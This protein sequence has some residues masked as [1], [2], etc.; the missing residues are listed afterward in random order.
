MVRKNEDLKENQIYIT[1]I[2]DIL[3][4]SLNFLNQGI[5][6]EAT[7]CLDIAYDTYK[8]HFRYHPELQEKLAL[9]TFI[10]DSYS[11]INPN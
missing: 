8:R 3:Q 7:H 5:I 10:H 1:L 9:T 2:G 4:D 6:R 11:R